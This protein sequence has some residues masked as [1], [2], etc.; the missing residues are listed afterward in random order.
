VNE[1]KTRVDNAEAAIV[2]EHI[3]GTLAT[4]DR[5]EGLFERLKV[6]LSDEA[7]Y[8]HIL[9]CADVL[10]D[11][12]DKTKLRDFAEFFAFHFCKG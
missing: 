12:D 11:E 2:I 3:I 7:V 5:V 1:R 10:D 8:E 4:I 9:T 6:V